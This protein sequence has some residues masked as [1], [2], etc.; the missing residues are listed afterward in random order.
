MRACGRSRWP[1][2][3]RD[4]EARTSQGTTTAEDVATAIGYEPAQIVKS[5]VFL[6]VGHRHGVEPAAGMWRRSVVRPNRLSTTLA[7]GLT[8]S[9]ALAQPTMARSPGR[10]CTIGGTDGPDRPLGGTPGA[11]VICGGS[12]ADKILGRGGNDIIYGGDG[13]DLIYGHAG[14]D[15][16]Y[17]GDDADEIRDG[18]GADEI[19]GQ[20]GGDLVALAEASDEGWGGP[21]NDGIAATKGT[22]IVHG[23]RGKDFLCARDGVPDDLLLGGP[24]RDRVP[25]DA[26]DTVRSVE[27]RFAVPACG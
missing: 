3:R 15:R 18:R 8:L 1:A 11:D 21:G 19:H 6:A 17:G 14:D 13:R 2:P 27:R 5:L 9:C 4:A 20:R 25:A 22:D 16:I 7:L 24:N 26:L 23:G 10:G 12:G